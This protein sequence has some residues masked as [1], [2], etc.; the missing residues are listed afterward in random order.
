MRFLSTSGLFNPEIWRLRKLDLY[1]I[2][3]FL[4][5]FFLAIALLI[6]IVI[7][8]DVSEKVDDFLEKQAPLSKILFSYYLSF[9]PYFVNLFSPLFTFIAVVYFTSKLATRSEIVAIL[10]SGISFNRLLRPY[11]ISAFVLAILT[12]YLANFLIPITNRTLLEFEYTYIKNKPKSSNRHIHMQ[13]RPGQ[14]IYI[15]SF[16]KELN[17][18]YRFTMEERDGDAMRGKMGASIIRWDSLTR[19]WSMDD[20]FIRSWDGHKERYVRGE[21]MDTLLPFT[22][23]DLAVSFDD[24]KLMNFWQL[25]EFIRQEEMKGN[26]GIIEYEVEKHRRIAFP[27][28]TVI[29]TL[30]GMALS[31]RK[32]RGGIGV[33]L[34]AGIAISFAFIL[35][36]QISTT[37]AIYGNLH[38]GL[39]VWVPNVLFGVLAFYLVRIAPK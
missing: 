6:L 20:Y 32:V 27:F 13:I 28:A 4:G 24:V 38:P 37:F 30:I 16:N 9:I 23:A 17:T 3:K 10:S 15:E 11:L 35:F 36:M 25:R 26:E 12:F 18:G 14:F 21:K 5:T 34:G 1:I 19:I 39:A 2:R 31:S 8:F 29:L 33:H 22:P 7:I